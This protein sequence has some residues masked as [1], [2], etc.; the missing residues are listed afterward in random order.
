MV[1]GIEGCR[2]F[3]DE[4]DRENFVSRIRRQVE[5]TGTKILAWALMDTHVHLLGDLSGLD[6][7]N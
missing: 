7:A 1:C 2:I 6:Q 4:Q 5:K 3:R